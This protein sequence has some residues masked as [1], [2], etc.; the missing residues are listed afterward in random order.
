MARALLVMIVS[1]CLHG[2]HWKQQ[3]ITWDSLATKV[4][5]E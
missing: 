2:D 4:D 1:G 5:R 3:V